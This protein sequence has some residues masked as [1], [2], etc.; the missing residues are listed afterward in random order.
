MKKRMSMFCAAAVLVLA[1]CQS[2]D[3][4]DTPGEFDRADGNV[5]EETIQADIQSDTDEG[6]T[7]EYERDTAPGQILPLTLE[8]MRK[9]I[10]EDQSFAVVFTK[11]NCPYCIEFM[12]IFEPY[13][14]SHNVTMYEVNLSNESKIENDNKMIVQTY[15]PEF[16]T[17]PG[18][19]S[20]KE[21]EEES[22]L[23]LYQLGIQESVIDQWVQAY[24]LDAAG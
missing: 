11:D 20:V 22:Y 18:V 23:N 7:A 4:A 5:Q 13:L 19:F 21:G 1:G 15:F 6:I 24:Q 2:K 16:N 3:K 8:G 17:V 14:Q 10:D 12:S 9:M